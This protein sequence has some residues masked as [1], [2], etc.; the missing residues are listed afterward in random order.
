MLLRIIIFLLLFFYANAQE[1]QNEPRY[2]TFEEHVDERQKQISDSVVDLF[3]YVDRKLAYWF[4]SKAEDKDET[5]L[6]PTKESIDEFF[7]NEKYI[8][9]NSKSYL[10]VRFKS[11]IQ[12]KGDSYIKP[13]VKIQVP[14]KRTQNNLHL[15]FNEIREDRVDDSFS[16][17][18]NKKSAQVGVN[19]FTPMKY[20]IKSKY[21]VGIR[22]LS[23][24]VSARYN[25]EFEFEKWIIE[26]TQE[27]KYSTKDDLS[28]ETNI[29]FDRALDESSLF[30]TT[31]TR[32]TQAHEDGF[33]Y[34]LALSYYL[35]LS[36]KKGFG[37]SQQFWGNSKYTCEAQPE[38]FSGISNY[39]TQFSWRQNIFRKWMTFEAQPIVSFHREN[40]YKP[41][42]MLR[43]YVDFYFGN[44]K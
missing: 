30:R 20:G 35:T 10:Q 44:I 9:E 43:F 33:D 39:A 3:D 25:K 19:Y 17:M 42:Y 2:Q 16:Q 4:N 31:L 28:E 13:S 38:R 36:N 11:L 21:S 29:Y 27:F 40:D 41:N 26:P 23:T 24:Y 15:F 32:K 7:K 37:F 18:D 8:K 14:L 5:G 22:S 34:A 6:S 1:P 12:S